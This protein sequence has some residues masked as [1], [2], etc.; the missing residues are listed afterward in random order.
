MY[1]AYQL[2]TY[3]NFQIVANTTDTVEMP[4]RYRMTKRLSDPGL[5]IN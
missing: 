1:S 4:L 3:R 5:L 2:F